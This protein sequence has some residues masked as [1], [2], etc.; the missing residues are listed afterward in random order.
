[1]PDGTMVDWNYD[2]SRKVA[3][4][5]T[6]DKNGKDATQAGFDPDEHRPVGLRAP[7][8]RPARHGR[9]LRRRHARGGRRQDRPDPRRRG[10]P[11]WKY[12][13]DAI[14]TRPRQHDRADLQSPDINPEDYPFFTGKIAMSEN[15]LW[16]TYGLEGAEG[17]WDMRPSRPTTAR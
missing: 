16:S 17:D 14:W 4:I 5:L 9:L 15:F 10:R 3:K 6:V 11:R 8:R 7:A 1:M 2:T 12:W 13:Y